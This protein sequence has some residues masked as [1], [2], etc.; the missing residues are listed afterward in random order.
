MSCP[1]RPEPTPTALR[2]WNPDGPREPF[3][4]SSPGL[5]PSATACP[6]LR[7]Q[8]IPALRL[9]PWL[10][11]ILCH[12]IVR[13]HLHAQ[14]FFGNNILTSSGNVSLNT[15]LPAARACGRGRFIQRVTRQRTG[16]GQTLVAGQPH[17][18][19]RLAGGCEIEPRPK[20]VETPDSGPKNGAILKG[21]RGVL[22]VWVV[23]LHSKHFDH[24]GPS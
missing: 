22:P 4:V 7:I 18:A 2:A 8:R 16:L 6:R 14:L 19:D 1:S 15:R 17:L 13:M 23:T 5:M 24:S 10:A 21:A 11:V 20:I 9:A 12:D 3:P